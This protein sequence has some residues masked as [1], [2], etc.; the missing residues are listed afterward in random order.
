[1]AI[2]TPFAAIRYDPLKVGGLER[3][4]TQPYDKITPQMQKDYFA[5]SPYNL[6]HI[7]RGETKPTDTPA[8][9]VYTRA[10]AYFRSWREQGVLVQRSGP[11]FYAYFQEFRLPGDPSGRR[12]TRKGFIGAGRLEDYSSGVIFRHEQTLSAPK[13]DRLEL[14][15]AT[16]AHFGQIFMLYSDEQRR[17]DQLLDQ[18]R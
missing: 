15:R 1:M 8:D 2:V 6:A 11:A 9:N 14:L 12:L 17:V 13:A 18:V 16:R 4:L 10:S 7:I 5:R 3:V